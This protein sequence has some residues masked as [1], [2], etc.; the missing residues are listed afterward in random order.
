MIRVSAE[1]R[2]GEMPKILFYYSF[3]A[4]FIYPSYITGS[5]GVHSGDD[6][7]I[8]ATGPQSHLF[9]GVMQ[10]STIPHLMAYAGCIGNG[11]TVCDN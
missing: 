9:S 4:V 1:V 2:L 11:P 5:I 8:F 7:G 10:Q 6:V 3:Y